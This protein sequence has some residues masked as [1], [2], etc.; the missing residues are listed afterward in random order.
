MENIQQ[1]IL[2]VL[3]RWRNRLFTLLSDSSTSGWAAVRRGLEDEQHGFIEPGGSYLIEE[4]SLNL[5]EDL[6][7]FF[8]ALQLLDQPVE[9]DP[10][11]E[12]RVGRLV[13]HMFELGLKSGVKHSDELRARQM[14]L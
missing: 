9:W 1:V 4:C 13:R 8:E 11:A 3:D 7:K 12:T 5:P 10:E 14:S 6:K 2:V